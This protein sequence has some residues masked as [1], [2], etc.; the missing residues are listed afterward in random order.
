M[1]A[2]RRASVRT[3]IA[4]LTIVLAVIV[5]TIGAITEPLLRGRFDKGIEIGRLIGQIG[6]ISEDFRATT[7][8]SQE[9]Q[10]LQKAR[11]SGL[12]VER[13]SVAQLRSNPV[14]AQDLSSAIR[15]LLDSNLF[16]E[17][18]QFFRSL[19]Q[20][21]LVVA[22]AENRGLVFRLP[23]FTLTKWILPAV[24]GTL[25]LILVPTAIL[26]FVSA[27]LIGRPIVQFAASAE[28]IATDEALDEPFPV[29]GTA[30]LRS[31]AYSLNIM[32]KR[33]LDLMQARTSM[34]TSISHDLR[35]PL[36]R[37]RMRAERCD[38][39]DLRFKML[40]DIEILGGMIDESLAYLDGTLEATKKVELSS[41]LQTVTSDFL[42]IGVEVEFKGPRRLIY[43][44]KPRA[45]SRVVSNLIDN[46]SRH[47]T[48]IAV[49]LAQDP[50][51]AVIIRVADDGPG[52]SDELKSHVLQPFFKADKA[53]STISGGGFGLGLSIAHGIITKGHG[54]TFDL[55][56]HD[57]HGLMIVMRLPAPPGA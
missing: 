52:L 33:V 48:H 4:V 23:S 17:P 20:P 55:H 6:M 56:D 24:I 3:Q 11:E 35:T 47:A 13:A 42:D 54:G 2:L 34:L 7:S 16:L 30:E 26:A 57:P 44:C 38:P 27:W 9:D 22:T 14:S 25:T 32:R 21:S 36:T 51:R 39:E 1:K 19:E 12:D 37:L 50:D 10:I 40:K 49:L 15:E 41:L 18:A 45:I 28:R 29:E 5:T 53:R 46:A 31:L 8:A 43:A